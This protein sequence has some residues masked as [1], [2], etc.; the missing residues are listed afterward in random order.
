MNRPTTTVPRIDPAD[1]SLPP[2]QP[3]DLTDVV[4]SHLEYR[5]PAIDRDRIL[6]PAAVRIG[7]V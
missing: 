3:I 4:R 2:T 6:S 5:A 1:V 7:R